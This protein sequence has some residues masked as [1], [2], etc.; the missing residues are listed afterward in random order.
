MI[1]FLIGTACLIGLIAQL[2]RARY[3]YGGCGGYGGHGYGHGGGWGGGGCGGGWH[4]KRWH[5]HHHGGDCGGG[6]G[7]PHRNAEGGEGEGFRGGPFGG[8]FRGGVGGPF[9]GFRGGFGGPFG[10]QWMRFVS[11]RLD[12]T[13]AQEKVVAQS[14]EEVRETLKKQKGTFK[15]SR[16]DIAKAIRA[17][18]FDAVVMGDLFGK[19][20]AAIDEVRKAIVG[21]LSRVHDALDEKQ[22]ERLAQ[23]LEGGWW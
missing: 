18:S 19:H 12:L 4:H 10:G 15:D 9:G 21:A 5:H 20:D 17:Q 6:F 14:F 1:G 16:G 7:G 13:P 23:M 22:R 3:G 8:G 11:E 2:K